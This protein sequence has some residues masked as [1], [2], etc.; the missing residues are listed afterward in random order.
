MT[1]LIKNDNIYITRPMF[2]FL[3]AS[4]L[5]KLTVIVIQIRM[6]DSI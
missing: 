6:E 5:L 2:I 3:Y 1:T 4:F